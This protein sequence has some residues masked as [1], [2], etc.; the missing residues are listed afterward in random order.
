MSAADLKKLIR[1][2]IDAAVSAQ[3]PEPGVVV[4]KTSG[5]VTAGRG[6]DDIPFFMDEKERD[7]IS[8]GVAEAVHKYL[9]ERVRVEVSVSVAGVQYGP[10]AASG[11]GSGTL[12]A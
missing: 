1:A 2:A 4:T 8:T 11:K 3:A 10:S 6:G 12:I 5:G 7:V 9:V